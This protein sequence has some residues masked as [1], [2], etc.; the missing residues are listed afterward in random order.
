MYHTVQD[1]NSRGSC[2]E[3]GGGVVSGNSVLS[4]Q[5]LCR[6]KTAPKNKVYEFK[7]I[8]ISNFSAHKVLLEHIH[9]FHLHLYGCYCAGMEE[10]RSCHSDQMTR[11]G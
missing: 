9:T 8:S 7:D 1:F 11:K 5:L 4:A 6:L 10:L 3:D 2:M